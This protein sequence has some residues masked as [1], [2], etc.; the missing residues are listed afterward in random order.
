MGASVEAIL[1][2]GLDNVPLSSEPPSNSRVASTP[3]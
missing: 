3:A 1:K 2:N